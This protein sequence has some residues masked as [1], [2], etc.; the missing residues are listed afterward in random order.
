M[1]P[2]RGLGVGVV[3]EGVW[4][5]GVGNRV[6]ARCRRGDPGVHGFVMGWIGHGRSLLGGALGLGAGLVRWRTGC[7]TSRPSLAL[8]PIP[9]TVGGV[10]GRSAPSALWFLNS[11][12]ILPGIANGC[13]EC[14]TKAWPITARP[15]SPLERRQLGIRVLGETDLPADIRSGVAR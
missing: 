12:R 11:R 10:R 6:T 13:G 1:S 8:K 15:P 14:C 7:G 5:S 4:G 2:A 3:F 9:K